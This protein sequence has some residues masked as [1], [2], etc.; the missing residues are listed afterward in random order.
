MIDKRRVATHADVASLA[1][2][3]LSWLTALS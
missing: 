2:A 1:T 3:L